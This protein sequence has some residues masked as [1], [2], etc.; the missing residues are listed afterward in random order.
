MR[1]TISLFGTLTIIGLLLF[2]WTIS[3]LFVVD[4]SVHAQ[5]PT[6]CFLSGSFTA[7]GTSTV[8]D[9]TTNGRNCNTWV[10]TVNASATTVTGLSIQLE[11]A[12]PGTSPS[13]SAVTALMQTGASA[14]PCT[15]TTGCLIYSTTYFNQYRVNLTSLTGTGTI[16][17]VLQGSSGVSAKNGLGGGGGGS[18]TGAA[19]GDLSGTYP[20]P[21]VA[22]VNGTSIPVNAAADQIINTTA[23][24]TG[25]W[26]SVPNCV[27]SG[28]NHLNYTTATHLLS[29][30]T[31]SSGGGGG[32]VTQLGKTVVGGAS[33]GVCS[34]TATTL[35]CT[36]IPGTSNNLLLTLD[37]ASAGAVATDNIAVAF[38]GDTAT[39]YNF[40]LSLAEGATIAGINSAG[41]AGNANV[42]CGAVAGTSAP[43]N[44]S[45]YEEISIHN[46][47]GTTFRKKAL[48]MFGNNGADASSNTTNNTGMNTLTWKSTAAITSITIVLA[49]GNSFVNG[50]TL[51]LYGVI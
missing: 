41:V 11:G 23:S 33:S 21:T 37:A 20:N 30:G 46:Y 32:A 51:I 7:T 45:V 28:G 40:E 35:T 36:T 24:A 29:C 44:E 48:C 13:F 39:N 12:G 3:P 1:A 34:S 19:G 17:Y 25:Q 15:T 22:K 27:D 14:N 47:A 5:A 50:S 16:T 49:S 6:N 8:L 38:N 4:H 26:T 2:C 31:T 18:P 10:L 42:G 43:A 9:N